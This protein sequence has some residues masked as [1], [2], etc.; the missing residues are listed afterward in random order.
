MKRL[1]FRGTVARLDRINSLSEHCPLLLGL[2]AGLG[3]GKTRSR[4]DAHFPGSALEHVAKDPGF[5]ASGRYLQVE[6]FTV[7]VVAGLSDGGD[8]SCGQLFVHFF[9][10]GT[11]NRTHK[12]HLDCAGF[13][14]TCPDEYLMML[15]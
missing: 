1:S 4:T 6:P 5:R 13:D 11:P 12:Q 3:K 14:W 15:E 2:D 8:A 9:R 10:H 7:D